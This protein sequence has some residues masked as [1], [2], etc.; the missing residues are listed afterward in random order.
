VTNLEVV[1]VRDKGGRCWWILH[2]GNIQRPI[3]LIDD[4]NMA[5]IVESVESQAAAAWDVPAEV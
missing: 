2:S 3:A 1:P 4:V 5:K